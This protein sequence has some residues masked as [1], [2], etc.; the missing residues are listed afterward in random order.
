MSTV[1]YDRH[2]GGVRGQHQGSEVV[3]AFEQVEAFAAAGRVVGPPML[4][5]SI[6]MAQKLR[7]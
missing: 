1:C 4:V 3:N 6:S 2:D 5:P 7:E